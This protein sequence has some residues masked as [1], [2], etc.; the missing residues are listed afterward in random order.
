MFVLEQ[1]SMRMAR[2]VDARLGAGLAEVSPD[3]AMSVAQGPRAGERN[4]QSD[5]IGNRGH[6]CR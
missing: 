1:A 6:G 2:S 3:L 4:R 5:R